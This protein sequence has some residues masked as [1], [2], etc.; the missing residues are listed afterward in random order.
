LSR[1]DWIPFVCFIGILLILTPLLGKYLAEVFQGK[2]T[3]LHPILGWL[4]TLC[5]RIGGVD[6]EEE[7][8]WGRYAKVMLLFNLW[9]FFFVLSVQ[10]LQFYLPFNPQHFENVP[11]PL[12]FNTAVSFVT[13]TNW[14]A[15][16]GETTLSYATQMWG[17]TVQNFLS[18]ATGTAV[19]FAFIRGFVRKQMNTIGNFWADLVRTLVYILLPIAFIFSFALVSQGVVQTL[20]P[21]AEA[22][23]LEG[24][25]QV[26]PVGP[27]ASQIAIKQIGTNGGGFYNTNSAHPFENPTPLSNFLEMLAIVLIPAAT[28]YAYGIL[29]GSK[30]HGWIILSIMFVIWL[31]GFALASYSEGLK[32]P[33]MEVAPYLEG[34]ET[35]F[36]ITDSILWATITTATANG[37]VNAMHDSLSPLA[38][39]IAMLNIMLSEL[40]FGGIGVGLCSMLMYILTTVFLSGLMVGRTPEYLGKKIEKKDILWVIIAILLPSILILV[41]SGISS[42]LPIALKSLSDQ[43]PHGL[44]QI[45][46]TFSSA[47]G[48]NGSAFAGINANTDYY[49]IVLGVVM[50]LGRLSILV[51]SL[52]VAGQL[53]KKK[54]VPPSAGTLSTNTFLFA[55]LLLCVILIVCALTFFPALSLGPIVEQILMVRGQ[56]FAMPAQA[57]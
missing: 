34:K 2:R 39:G 55:A 10:M 6:P 57:G 25:K 24:A 19:L 29:I 5:Y 28:V 35:R 36:G 13:N 50:I 48:N 40:V 31:G 4:E 23:T 42:V 54:I 49:N 56:G 20:S 41:G 16:A 26:I 38:G 12:A 47:A 14:Q 46:Y 3:L 52:A 44:T 30:R 8:D 43:G 37:S 15:Y 22:T 53:A 1:F 21:Y 11:W 32:N 18:A 9:S 45:L 17:L 51:P 27:A 33:I 7:M